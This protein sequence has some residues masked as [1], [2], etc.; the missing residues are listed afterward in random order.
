ML[1]GVS[2][3]DS[4]KKVKNDKEKYVFKGCTEGFLGGCGSNVLLPIP[5]MDKSVGF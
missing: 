4:N 1:A 3:R 2:H 5:D